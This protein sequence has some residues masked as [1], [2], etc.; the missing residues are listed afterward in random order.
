[1]SVGKIQRKIGERMENRDQERRGPQAPVLG[2]ALKEKVSVMKGSRIP[3]IRTY[4]PACRSL[5][6]LG[7]YGSPR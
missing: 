6:R 5:G 4:T 3:C 7:T 2:T 1:M